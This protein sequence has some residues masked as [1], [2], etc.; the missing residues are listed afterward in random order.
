MIDF[1][2]KNGNLLKQISMSDQFTWEFIDEPREE[3]FSQI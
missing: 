3:G 2:D 1:Y